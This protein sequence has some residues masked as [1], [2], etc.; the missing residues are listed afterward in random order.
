MSGQP[1]THKRKRSTHVTPIDVSK[2][3]RFMSQFEAHR[4]ELQG[5]DGMKAEITQ[6]VRHK[7][8]FPD[9][10]DTE[11]RNLNVRPGRLVFKRIKVSELGDE[12]QAD[13]FANEELNDLRS[14]L[15]KIY[16]RVNMHCDGGARIVLDAILLSVGEIASKNST[17]RDIAIIPG[18]KTQDTL[19]T[20][21]G[22]QV[23][24][25]GSVDYRVVEYEKDPD[26]DN[27]GR[28]FDPQTSDKYVCE[29][30]VGHFSLVVAK[31]RRP[32]STET[33]FVASIPEAV[34][35]AMSFSVNA[36]KNTTHFC[37]SDGIYFI[38]FIL[39]QENG[40]FTYY[41]SLTL[42]LGQ[43]QDLN[44]D[45]RLQEIIQLLLE[46][47]NPCREDL[48]ELKEMVITDSL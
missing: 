20:N 32:G 12:T 48:F 36:K 8:L 22:Y 27:E 23:S 38:F 29:I 3:R 13:E 1:L 10:S 45:K 19:F 17:N 37:L 34:A 18:L 31:P 42:E 14:R 7:V 24:F 41:Q 26:N 30:A 11:L 46:W 44:F 40:S 6:V 9:V 33:G 5:V 28:L 39:K 43:P 15:E 35:Q 47:L 16:R 2:T 21:D 4:A 25:G